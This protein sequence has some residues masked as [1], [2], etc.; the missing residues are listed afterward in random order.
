MNKPIHYFIGYV[1]LFLIIFVLSC[2]RDDDNTHQDDPQHNENLQ[3]VGEASN[4]LL[5]GEK[6]DKITFEVLA[7]E[8]YEPDEEVIS[9]FEGFL[10]DYIHK[11]EGITINTTTVASP[12]ISSYTA[13]KIREFEDNNRQAYNEGNEITV[14]VFIADGSYDNNNVLGVAYRST[15]FALMGER[16]KELT[17]GVGQPSENLVL[18]TVMRHEMG[19]ILGLVNVG[20]PMQED[21]Q[22]TDHGKH[23]DV[24]DCLMYYA[25]ETGDFLDNL[26]GMSNPPA[27]DSQCEADLTANGGK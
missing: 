6:Y 16:I 20:T 10:E 13:D 5:S 17:G 11:P 19:H 12:E 9:S 3:S 25:V 7:V 22:D 14:F 27:F 23:C 15:S 8:G 18:Q 2:S 26:V 4:D 21:H 1:T 24:D